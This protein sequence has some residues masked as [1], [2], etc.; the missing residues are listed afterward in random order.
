MTSFKKWQRKN[1][2]PGRK[3]KIDVEHHHLPAAAT[4]YHFL[5]YFIAGIYN[6]HPCGTVKLNTHAY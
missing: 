2:N 6:P 5:I 4:N 1:F 3:R